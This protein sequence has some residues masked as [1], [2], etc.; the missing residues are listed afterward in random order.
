[1]SF[2]QTAWFAAFFLTIALMPDSHAMDTTLVVGKGGSSSSD[3][4]PTTDS[5]FADTTHAFGQTIAIHK[6]TSLRQVAVYDWSGTQYVA[7]VYCNG[8]GNHTYLQLTHNYIPAGKSYNGHPLYKTSIPGFYFTVQM[9]FIQ[10]AVNMTQSSF[11]FDKTTTPIT[12]EFTKSEASCSQENKYTNLGTLMYGVK[13][14]AYV[15]ADF[16]PT[17][18]QIQSFT[19]SKNGDSD[20]YIDNPGGG[21]SNYKMKFNFPA[22]GLNAVWPTC[23]A[24]TISGP[25]VKGSTLDFGAFYAKEIIAGLSAVPFQINLSDCAYIK[26]IE[27]KLT[28]TAIGKDTSLLSNTLTGNTAVSGIGVQ[29]EGVQTNLS[30][31]MVL[32]PGDTNSVYKYSPYTSHDAYAGSDNTYT[33]NTLNFLATLKPDSNQTITPGSFKA[34]GTFQITYP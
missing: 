6:E 13:I 5:I 23:S 31:Q 21:L 15:D 7:E 20:F 17:E 11:W 10:P 8:G 19:L 14:Y 34:T 1:M 4:G 18:A 2:K 29:I 30:N 16:A 27:V 9:V 32:I 3:Y 22:I 28:S 33:A 24:S 12:S 25:N 26:N